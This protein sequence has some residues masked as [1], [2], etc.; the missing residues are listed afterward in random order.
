MNTAKLT[1]TISKE[2]YE[3]IEKE[4]KRRGL[5][6]SALVSQMIGFFFEKEKEREKEKKYVAGYRKR[7]E[8]V[9]ELAV[10]EK[11]QAAVLG[12]F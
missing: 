2:Q 11:V 12:E 5:T 3:R 10:I 6:R 9:E 7:P 8:L 4:K 1:V